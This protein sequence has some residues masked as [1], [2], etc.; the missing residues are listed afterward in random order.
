MTAAAL[1]FPTLPDSPTLQRAGT[2]DASKVTGAT[3]TGDKGANSFFFDLQH[4]SGKDH[5]TDFGGNDV[6]V[7]KGALY[8]GNHDGQISFGK[9]TVNL[10]GTGNVLTID[11]VNALRSL[12]TDVAG[13]NVYATASVR[14][15][16]AIEGKLTDDTLA[17]DNGD[18][19]ADKFFL[20]TAL[21]LD[22]G[23]DQVTKFG[24]KDVLI[25]TSALGNQSQGETLA[26][27]GGLIKLGGGD[28]GSVHLT[29]TNGTDV[30]SIDFEGTAIRG[31]VT[32]YVYATHG[33][34]VTV[35]SAGF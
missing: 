10:G 23:S 29:N 30:G 11:G 27:S 5:V 15:S 8:D 28:L 20:D 19:K 31:D 9:Q 18:R 1:P 26:L 35:H 4:A 32:Y 3:F 2:V 12:G 34:S 33:S 22:L 6:L 24:A 13:L 17:G 16:G 14:P 25:T 21:G 7:T